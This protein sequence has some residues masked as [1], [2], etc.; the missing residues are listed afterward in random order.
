MPR[1]RKSDS[2]E[3]RQRVLFAYNAD[4]DKPMGITFDYLLHNERIP[5]RM[6]K[7]KGLEAIAAFW[8]PFAYQEIA[9][10]SEEEVLA[11]A[12][13][14]LTTLTRQ[15]DLICQTFGLDN[16][17]AEKVSPE[18]KQTIQETMGQ[19]LQQFIVTGVLAK[20][21][22]STAPASA[23]PANNPEALLEPD[24]VHFDEDEAL[25]ELLDFSAEVE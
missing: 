2:D 1:K 10:A 5:P 9:K 21:G 8:Q 19:V 7:D 24:D 14:S 25:G 17:Q 3:G 18:L 22:G 20:H 11:I 4:K 12:R 23:Q 16:P 15:I 6:G 13:E